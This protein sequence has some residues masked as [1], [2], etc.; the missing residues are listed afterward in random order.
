MVSTSFPYSDIDFKY[1][2]PQ[3]L[4]IEQHLDAF[5]VVFGNSN[6]PVSELYPNM[7]TGKEYEI[8][9]PFHT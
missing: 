6:L 4:L 1:S 3:T 2:D 9:V 8:K 5:G 7:V